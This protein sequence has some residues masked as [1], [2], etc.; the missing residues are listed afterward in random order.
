MTWPLE[1]SSENSTLDD[2]D[3]IR[4][5]NC[6]ISL[7]FKLFR[8]EYAPIAVYTACG[9]LTLCPVMAICC[10]PLAEK[11]VFLSFTNFI[12]SF[13]MAL[14]SGS[15]FFLLFPSCLEDRSKFT[16]E[17]ERLSWVFT[18]LKPVAE[19]RFYP[20]SSG[21]RLWPSWRNYDHSSSKSVHGA[22]GTY[23]TASASNQKRPFASRVHFPT[24]W[25]LV[26]PG[27]G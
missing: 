14:A 6:I 8:C 10:F 19:T 4:Y 12:L 24:V 9:L 5:E 13:A 27:S 1:C 22:D 20:P 26:W 11:T 2:I 15:L 17:N 25:G 18:H 7:G 21:V 16:A 23:R 3:L